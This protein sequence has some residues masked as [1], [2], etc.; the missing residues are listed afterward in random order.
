MNKRDMS[1]IISQKLGIKRFEAYY[2]IDFMV[3]AM[4]DG[5]KKDSKIVFSNFG[6]LKVVNRSSKK[7]INPNTK[8]VMT[9][10]PQKVVKFTPSRTLKE[11][12]E[13]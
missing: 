12:V 2:F 4:S 5:L 10:N 9:I 13:D 1:E 6:T 7:V 3:E 8:G 11:A